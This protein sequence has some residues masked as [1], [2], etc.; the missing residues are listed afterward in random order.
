M[1]T[2]MS[3]RL[4]V[5]PL[6][7]KCLADTARRLAVPYLSGDVRPPA[8]PG[9]STHRLCHNDISAEHLIVDPRSG[10]IVGLLD[11]T[12]AMVTDPVVDFVGLITVGHYGFISDVATAYVSRGGQVIDASFWER[13][14]WWCR[15]LTLTWLGEALEEHP[16]EA[17]RH[18]QWVE[19]AFAEP[20]SHRA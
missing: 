15:T 2:W 16:S 8:N 13:L 12:D 3:R 1:S 6:V 11:W 9:P 7:G 20:M 5:A 18:I 10:R 19:R 14:V 17:D 4:T